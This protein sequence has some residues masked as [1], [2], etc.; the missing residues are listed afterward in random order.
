M[1]PRRL[2]PMNRQYTQGLDLFPVGYKATFTK[3]F[4]FAHVDNPF[5]KQDLTL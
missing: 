3:Q 1:S 4:V 2:P 5:K